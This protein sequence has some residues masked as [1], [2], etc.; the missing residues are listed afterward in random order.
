MMKMMIIFVMTSGRRVELWTFDA[1]GES[2]EGCDESPKKGA[3]EWR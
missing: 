3:V 2:D 1:T